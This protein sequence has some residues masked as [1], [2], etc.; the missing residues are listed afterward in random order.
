M[1]LKESYFL[2]SIM[3]RISKCVSQGAMPKKLP[4]LWR[5]GLGV[6][7]LFGGNLASLLRRNINNFLSTLYGKPFAARALFGGYFKDIVTIC[8]G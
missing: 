1:A 4:S 7:G 5:E 2:P 6:S 8:K 3:Q